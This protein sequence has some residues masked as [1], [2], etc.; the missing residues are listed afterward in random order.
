MPEL[1]PVEGLKYLNYY[2]SCLNKQGHL[3]LSADPLKSKNEAFD[4]IQLPISP[5][6]QVVSKLSSYSLET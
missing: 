5:F 3:V 2:Y 1:R 4:H 6:F